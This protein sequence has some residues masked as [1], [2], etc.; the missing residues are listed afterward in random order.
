M[1]IFVISLPKSGTTALQRSFERLGRKALHAHNDHT[2]YAAFPNGEIL[3]EA[4]IGLA[5]MLRYRKSL[6]D[7]PIYIFSG[8][9]DPISWYLSLAGHFS[10]PLNRSLRNN[11]A[12]YITQAAP[13]KEYTFADTVSVIEAG[14]GFS[15]LDQPFN[16]DLGYHVIRQDGVIV[17]LYRQDRMQNLEAFIQEEIDGRFVLSRER[18]NNDDA[19]IKYK[20]SFTISPESAE[21]IINDSVFSYFYTADERSELLKRY[22][23]TNPNPPLP[24]SPPPGFLRTI[25]TAGITSLKRCMGKEPPPEPAPCEAAVMTLDSLNRVVYASLLGR[26][27]DAAPRLIWD[28]QDAASVLRDIFASPEFKVRHP[29]IALSARAHDMLGRHPRIVDTALDIMAPGRQGYGGL[30]DHYDAEIIGFAPIQNPG[31]G[32]SPVPGTQGLTLLPHIL[33]DG[34]E[35]TL[36]ITNDR[37]MS[38]FYPLNTSPN[39]SFER[40][41]PLHVVETEIVQTHRLDDVLPHQAIDLLSVDGRG[42]TLMILEHAQEILKQT[43][44][45]LCSVEFSPLYAGQ[46]LFGDV[47]AYMSS[48]GF[49]FLDFISVD[50]QKPI[51][52]SNLHGDDRLMQGRVLFARTVSSSEAKAAQALILT[53]AFHKYAFTESLLDS[54]GDTPQ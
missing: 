29:H 20:N 50:G 38:S 40:L 14:V 31:G 42:S 23:R 48:Q 26:H 9:R 45:V 39:A 2:T 11:I 27:P 54:V 28:D 34:Q 1:D 35:R 44:M 24:P 22:V 30:L 10:L 6:S 36:Y 33:G 4:G 5:T 37:S 8:Y 16:H 41:A 46:A 47:A 21:H 53:A 19:Y 25:L 32:I 12:T 52:H 18:D 3:R 49:Y 7:R 51:N 13:W 17:V 15:I 43:T